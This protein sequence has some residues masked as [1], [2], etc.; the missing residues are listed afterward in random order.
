M[1]QYHATTILCVIRDGAVAIGGGVG[2]LAATRVAMT[3]M[4]EMV[5]LLNGFGG[6]ASL[7]GPESRAISEVDDF[8]TLEGLR[9]I[10]ERNHG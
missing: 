9:I 7:I 4:P 6:L 8:L 3:S 1:Q 5:A 2:A 10:F